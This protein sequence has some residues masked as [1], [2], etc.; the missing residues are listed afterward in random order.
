MGRP[1]LPV[2]TFGTIGFFPTAGGEVQARARFRDF[3]GRTRLVSKTGRSKAA[4]ERALKTELTTRRGPHGTGLLTAS[5]RVTALVD[6]WLATDHGWSTGTER[7]YRSIIRTS[8]LPALG[9]LCLRE[10]TP[11][12]WRGRS[13]RSPAPAARVRPRPPEPACRACSPWPSSTAPSPPTRSG[14]P[15][16]GSPAL[17]RRPREP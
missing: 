4:A 9:E 6:A 7:T 1:P 14:T 13:P 2:G 3:D 10:V 8:V 5:S 11:A 16:S 15:A 17:P 12:G